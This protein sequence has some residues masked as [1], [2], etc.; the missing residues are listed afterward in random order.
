M[1]QS[2]SKKR[3]FSSSEDSGFESTDLDIEKLT[4]LDPIRDSQ[5]KSTKVASTE[6]RDGNSTRSPAIRDVQTQSRH[7][8]SSKSVNASQSKIWDSNS[9]QFVRKNSSSSPEDYCCDSTDSEDNTN[10]I[11]NSQNLKTV[12][13][14]SSNAVRGSSRSVYSSSQ[15]SNTNSARKVQKIR[16]DSYSS[17]ASSSSSDSDAGSGFNPVRQ[18]TSF[19]VTSADPRIE[20]GSF[21]T[22]R[23]LD[24]SYLV[25]SGKIQSLSE[26]KLEDDQ[27][28]DSDVNADLADFE[29]VDEKSGSDVDEHVKADM[30]D[31]DRVGE[32]SDSDIEYVYG[33]LNSIEDA[34]VDLAK[35][36][37]VTEPSWQPSR[38][39]E[40]VS[41]KSDLA[42]EPSWQPSRRPKLAIE[43]LLKRSDEATDVLS[44][45]TSSRQ[46]PATR[47][48]TQIPSKQP[49]QASTN[50][51]N[52]IGSL[53]LFTAEDTDSD[54]DGSASF[55]SATEG[56]D[57]NSDDENEFNIPAV[58][59]VAHANMN[60]TKNINFG[61]DDIT[62][63]TDSSDSEQES[64]NQRPA[65]LNFDPHRHMVE[66]ETVVDFNHNHTAHLPVQSFIDRIDNSWFSRD[67]SDSEEE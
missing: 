50:L 34:S 23:N 62:D 17:S 2:R 38:P 60:P 53:T 9:W 54:S 22:R 3:T 6:H 28:T 31:F 14:A 16:N 4:R 51:I 48:S 66:N 40:V 29:R 59:A 47:E 37:L 44:K 64:A 35:A 13:H 21:N 33:F 1:W 27:H 42:P 45:P 63:E 5:R 41:K 65:L 12:A 10:A 36:G 46:A 7:G 32:K 39:I 49:P 61:S 56:M 24:N 52:Q 25:K 30:A 26:T 19:K 15:S 20:L 67:H 11:P 57:L 58:S 43:V 55:V 8:S 18:P